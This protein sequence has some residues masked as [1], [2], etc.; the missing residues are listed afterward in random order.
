MSKKKTKKDINILKSVKEYIYLIGDV[1][2][3]NKGILIMSI[4]YVLMHFY[5][6]MMALSVRYDFHNYLAPLLFTTSWT[7]FFIG[8]SV[9]IKD[10]LGKILYALFTTSFSILF[11]VNGIYHSMM[12]TYFDFTLLEA[13]SEGVPYAL[14]AII[15]CNPLIY[16]AFATIIFTMILGI[17]YY[18]KKEHASFKRVCHSLI[19]FM[20]LHLIAPTFL[21]PA[22]NSLTWSNWRNARN[23][24]NQFNDVN[25]SIKVS[26]FF[27]YEIRNFYITFLKSEGNIKDEDIDFLEEAFGESTSKKNKYTGLLKGK[28]LIIIQLEG[29][30]NWILNEKN[31]PTLYKLMNEGINFT[32]H[33]SFYNGGGSTFNSEFAI[34]TGFVT[35]YSYTK[36]AYTFNKNSFPYS[37]PN[38]FKGMD[39]RVDAY[40]MNTGEYYS[41]TINYLNWGYDSYNGL[42]EL[43]EYEGEKYQ[44][45]R[46]LILNETFN[47][48]M[49]DTEK[50]F[51]NYIITYSG[52]VPFTNKKAVCKYLYEEENP[53]QNPED[54]VEMTEEECIYRQN[55]ET[56]DM[57]KLLL[58]N[59]KEKKLLDKTAIV[60]VTDH[61]LFTV[62]DHSLLEKN[63]ETKN[64]L[65][66]HTPFFIWYKGCKATKIKTVTSQLDILPTILNLYGITY[67]T[68]NYIGN[69]ALKDK[70]KGMVYFNDYSWY[71]GNVYVENGEVVNGKKISDDELTDKNFYV[72]YQTRK[73]DLA[74][75]Y[76]YFKFKTE[77]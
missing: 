45:D 24:Y 1:I 35:P 57:V 28:N 43:N 59:L 3:N 68:N 11:L 21:G 55:K 65:I 16:V 9:N 27:E 58:D 74:L 30:D 37:L 66:N 17:K 19:A 50:K 22:E 75:K 77:K 32:N 13:T 49:F 63:K 15:K 44:L 18:P 62:N 12:K 2:K 41:R 69:D 54:F 53:N 4:P 33:Y 29:M 7:I 67:N 40:H 70:Y 56:D 5:V 38:I 61:Y 51:V 52:H 46:E 64:N 76:N 25:K 14:E 60:F 71:D 47:K 6:V 73:N 36:N 26:G 42:A 72:S 31:T 48:K 34:N 23:I 39:Y 20:I 10:R 8:I